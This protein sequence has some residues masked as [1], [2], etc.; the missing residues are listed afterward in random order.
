[1]RAFKQAAQCLPQALAQPLLALPGALMSGVTQIRLRACQP[2]VLCAADGVWYPCADGTARREPGPGCLRISKALLA[3]CFHAVCGYSLHAVQHEVD[4]GFVTLAGGHRVGVCGRMAQLEGARWCV[5]DITSMNVRI[6][7]TVMCAVPPG[8]ERPGPDGLLI[9][10]APG[11]GKTTLLRSLAARWAASGACVAVVDERREL[12][13]D[14]EGRPLHCDVFS[15]YPKH[16]GM[17]QALRAFSPD[18]IVCDEIGSQQ[19]ARAVEQAANAGVRIAATIHAASPA[20][21]ARRPQFCAL[22]QTGAFGRVV[23]LRGATA[24]GAVAEVRDV[25]DCL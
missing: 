16:I 5:R 19:D 1:M 2:A 11:S 3:E 22:A 12:F 8:L 24:P 18:V 9:A 25:A 15:G 20:G 6:A 10:G 14:V 21:L 4:Q 17:M 23:F 7:R 13:P